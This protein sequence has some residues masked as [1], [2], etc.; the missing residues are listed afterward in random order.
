MTAFARVESS[1][2][3]GSLVWEVR[4]VNHRYLEPHFRL[5][6][7]MREIETRLRE[8]LRKGL[9]RGKVECN[10]KL[11][12]AEESEKISLNHALIQQLDQA[13]ENICNVVD[14]TKKADPLD[15]LRWPGVLEQSEA[16][17]TQ[18]Q[19]DAVAAFK[20]ALEQVRESRNR[21]GTEL[22]QFIIQRLES[23]NNE[24]AVVRKHMP[25]L[26]QAQRDKI[27]Q[28]LA[29]AAVEVDQ[30]RLEQELVMLAQKADVEEELD[31]LDTHVNEV[32]R[33]L[34]GKGAVGRR[35]DFLMQELNREANTLGSKAVGVEVTQSAVNLKVLIEQMREQVQN[36]E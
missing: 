11:M 5:P 34:N 25:E 12:L 27:T 2:S 9:N 4:T 8:Q 26:L 30:N 32:T 1:H 16:D 33:V 31:R 7:S 10:L 24:S 18:I 14:K 6:D 21:E 35:L 20:G 13:L 22:K 29:D 3:W 36:I 28:R 15:I 17:I 19:N 23:I